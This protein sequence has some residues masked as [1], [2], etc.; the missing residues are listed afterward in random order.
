MISVGHSLLSLREES[1][2]K[3]ARSQ[4]RLWGLSIKQQLVLRQLHQQQPNNFSQIHAAYHLLK[5]VGGNNKQTSQTK[6]SN[7][8]KTYFSIFLFVFQ[9]FKYFLS[10]EQSKLNP[11]GKQKHLENCCIELLQAFMVLRGWL[12]TNSG[13]SSRATASEVYVSS[14]TPLRKKTLNVY[15]CVYIHVDTRIDRLLVHNH[16]VLCQDV[17]QGTIVTKAAPFCVNAHPSVLALHAL[18]V[19]NLL[20]VAGVRSCTYSGKKHGWGSSR[21]WVHEKKFVKNQQHLVDYCTQTWIHTNL[22]RPQVQNPGF[23]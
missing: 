13:I 2:L 15:D 9:H 20:H 11:D 4:Q 22:L 10:W 14:L 19:P 5:A 1:C 23:R 3:F 16:V 12:I 7:N 8:E 21:I 18:D 17:F 6:P